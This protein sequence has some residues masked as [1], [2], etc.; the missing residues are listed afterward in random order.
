M[1]VLAI[2][3]EKLAWLAEDLALKVDE[4]SAS[5]EWQD[6]WEK[7]GQPILDTKTNISYFNLRNK[8]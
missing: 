6:Q 5:L 3:L 8:G 1:K 7:R 2:L 4:Q